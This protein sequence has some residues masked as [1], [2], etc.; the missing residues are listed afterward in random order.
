MTFAPP[1]SGNPRGP[2]APSRERARFSSEFISALLR[3]FR[4]GGPAAIA[5]VRKFQ[6]GAYMKICALLV[7]R[8]LKVE[9]NQGVKAMTDEQLEAAIEYIEAALAAKAS[10]QAKVIEGR[11]EPAALPAPELEPQR[12]RPNRLLEHAD[13]AIGPQERKPRKRVPSPAST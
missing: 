11:V 4:Q 3:D 9:Q 1:G 7:P 8:E 10:D 2:Y 5:K 6:P 12:K 13:S